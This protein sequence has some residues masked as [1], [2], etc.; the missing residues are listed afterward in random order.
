MPADS[1]IAAHYWHMAASAR[2]VHRERSSV[3]IEIETRAD[4]FYFDLM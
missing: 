1:S 3:K 4:I 2:S